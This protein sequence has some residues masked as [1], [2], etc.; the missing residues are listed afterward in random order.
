MKTI[1]KNITNVIE[2]NK[3]TFI[4]KL[5]KITSV[6]SI[7][8]VL[9]NI[10]TEYK[11]ATHYCYAYII[12]D[13]RKS[14]DDG[15]PGGTAGV[16]IMEVLLKNE[17]NYIL[18]VVIRYFGGIKLGSSGL[19]KTYRKSVVDALKKDELIKLIDGYKIKIISD[20]SKQKQID[21]L[22]KDFKYTKSYNEN[23][24]YIADIDETYLEKLVNQNI[25]ITILEKKK[26]EV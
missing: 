4:T 14:S 3:S 7:K 18:C 9:D 16:P 1:T 24:E 15:E 5:I 20:Y 26:I 11:D 10:K 13:N 25:K 12:D 23:I 19:I 22:L 6:D 2:V 8:E 21:F 17:L